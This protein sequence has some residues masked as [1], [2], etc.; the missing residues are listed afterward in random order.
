MIS[1]IIKKILSWCISI[2]AYLIM[3]GAGT[4]QRK[5]VFRYIFPADTMMSFR[6]WK[7]ILPSN[8]EDVF[9]ILK[10]F[11]GQKTGAVKSSL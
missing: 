8:L 3:R 11:S 2:K 10:D 1:I 5:P 7:D 4:D 9:P 6:I